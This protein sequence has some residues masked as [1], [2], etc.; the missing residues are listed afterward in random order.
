M[1]FWVGVRI[2]LYCRTVEATSIYAS[3]KKRE[4]FDLLIDVAYFVQ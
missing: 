2:P 1:C 3:L 4:L